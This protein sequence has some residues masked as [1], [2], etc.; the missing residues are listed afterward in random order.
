MGAKVL[1][2]R[3]CGSSY[4][5][6]QKCDCANAKAINLRAC[7]YCGVHMAEPER[8]NCR[9]KTPMLNGKPLDMGA[10]NQ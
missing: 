2:C 8:C 4:A 1:L 3:K 5:G 7:A 10:P 9:N 6:R